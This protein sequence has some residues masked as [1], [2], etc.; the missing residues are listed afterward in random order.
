MIGHYGPVCLILPQ[1]TLLLNPYALTGHIIVQL[2]EDFGLITMSVI[3]GR[4][5]YLFHEGR[6]TAEEL[7]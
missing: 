4:S 7:K 5:Q 6:E 2:Y 3:Y 1:V